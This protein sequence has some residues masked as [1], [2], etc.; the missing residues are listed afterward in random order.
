MRDFNGQT[1]SWQIVDGAI[2][3]VLHR[4]PCNEIGS[5]TLEELEK[6]AT[7]LPVLTNEVHA[8]IIH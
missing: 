2:E 7:A 8:V 4:D 5:R 3:L 1:L 6:F